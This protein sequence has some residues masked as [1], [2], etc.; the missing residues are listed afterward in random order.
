MSEPN[1]L[2][3]HFL[4]D[5]CWFFLTAKGVPFFFVNKTRK[6]FF[7]SWRHL[8]DVIQ[9]KEGKKGKGM[10]SEPTKSTS[11]IIAQF[12]SDEG[13]LTG[14]EVE[15]PVGTTTVQLEQIINHLLKNVILPKLTY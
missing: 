5:A 7:M 14:P 12:R 6:K 10:E 15:L 1:V 9:S 4:F 3:S 2:V 13:E 8:H 11:S